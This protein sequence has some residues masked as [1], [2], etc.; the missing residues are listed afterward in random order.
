LIILVVRFLNRLFFSS[1]VYS[2]N[3]GN[4]EPHRNQ[5]EGSV[6]LETKPGT[7]KRI[8]KDEGEY[9]DYEEVK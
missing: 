7:E 4:R 8:K 5:R 1:Y 3:T 6:T 2:N 9:I